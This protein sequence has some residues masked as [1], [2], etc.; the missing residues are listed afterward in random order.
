MYMYYKSK[1][2]DEKSKTKD[3]KIIYLSNLCDIIIKIK[4]LI[5][6]RII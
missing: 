1:T 4:L 6:L 5:K 2:N 3:D